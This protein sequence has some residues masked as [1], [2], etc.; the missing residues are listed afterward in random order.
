M[1]R[2]TQGSHDLQINK[3]PEAVYDGDPR[4]FWETQ[5]YKSARFGNLAN[6]FGVVLNMGKPVHVSK[7]TVQTPVGG[8]PIQLRI[9][10][11]EAFE[12][13]RLAGQETARHGGFSIN[14]SKDVVGQYVLIWFTNDVPAGFKAKLNEVTVHGSPA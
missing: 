8:V 11:S 5:T 9:G 1:E 4:T 7:V 14:A 13:M 6:G 12:A 3:H 2:L 10:K